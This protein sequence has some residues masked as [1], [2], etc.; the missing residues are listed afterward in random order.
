MAS[1]YM[2]MP[3]GSSFLAD[4]TIQNDLHFAQTMVSIT[5]GEN[6]YQDDE[7]IGYSI[8]YG[9]TSGNAGISVPT[10]TIDLTGAHEISSNE[11]VTIFH[12]V[13][14]ALGQGGGIRF[15]GR[16]GAQQVERHA[17]GIYTTQLLC[18]SDSV[19]VFRSKFATLIDPDKTITD[20]INRAK[21]AVPYG[22]TLPYG[23]RVN[24]QERLYMPTGLDFVNP[25]DLWAALSR[26]GISADH[27]RDG[28]VLFTPGPAHQVD[29]N[30]ALKSKQVPLTADQV[31]DGVEAEQTKTFVD[32]ALRIK[33]RTTAAVRENIDKSYYK[34]SPPLPDEYIDL[35]LSEDIVYKTRSWE[36]PVRMHHATKTGTGWEAMQL[37]LEVLALDPTL[38]SYDAKILKQLVTYEE[39]DFVKVDPSIS[40]VFNGWK[41]LLG[42]TEQCTH[43]SWNFGLNLV[44]PVIAYGAPGEI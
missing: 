4:W 11:P 3:R 41:Y 9:K 34:A 24:D 36:Y 1:S 27:K 8:T 19:R 35:D 6:T 20:A 21:N 17:S 40:P 31:L 29:R 39:G 12:E 38:P 10:A 18:T 32:A 16:V 28:T 2:Q 22:D 25:S 43:Q 7:I 14:E 33:Y 42:Y 15:V 37:K 5:V 26:N 44:S 30:N 23:S 13:A